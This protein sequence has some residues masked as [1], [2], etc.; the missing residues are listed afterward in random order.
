MTEAKK[1][2]SEKDMEKAKVVSDILPSLEAEK[3]RLV[4]GIK[5]D[6]E[7]SIFWF[8]FTSYRI[9]KDLPATYATLADFVSGEFDVKP[10]GKETK[11]K[12]IAQIVAR[13]KY[14]AQTGDPSFAKKK[15]DKAKEM[16][17]AYAKV[18]KLLDDLTNVE[19][20][21]L[22]SELETRITAYDNTVKVEALEA[23][24]RDK[25]ANS[26]DVS[27]EVKEIV[28]LKKAA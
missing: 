24:M 8:K 15:T 17:T 22:I 12:R 28:K 21:T 26:E 4:D 14:L 13:I 1:K 3:K 19:M 7:S 20:L 25:Q 16:V 5:A 9:Y 27:I 11:A 23:V 10:T 2:I 6:V 18:V